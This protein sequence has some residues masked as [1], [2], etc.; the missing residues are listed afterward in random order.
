[1]DKSAST[2]AARKI[3]REFFPFRCGEDA[4]AVQAFPAVEPHRIP[5]PCER[6][7]RPGSSVHAGT[8]PPLTPCR[9][10]P[11]THRESES[12]REYRTL[13]AP[14]VPARS[15]EFPGVWLLHLQA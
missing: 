11:K 8:H 3:L 14:S 6:A 2:S 7:I 10:R 15:S 5:F 4:A 9:D 12:P 1:M 13:A